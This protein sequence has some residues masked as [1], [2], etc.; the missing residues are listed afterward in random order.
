MVSTARALTMWGAAA[1]PCRTPAEL[2]SRADAP[3]V[4]YSLSQLHPA[5][6]YAGHPEL[7]ADLAGKIGQDSGGKN[8]GRASVWA[9]AFQ[10]A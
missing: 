7:K 10:A 1:A 8:T 6:L 2:L 5:A 9:G 4:Y 3:P